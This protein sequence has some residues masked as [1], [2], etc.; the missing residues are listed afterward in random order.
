MRRKKAASVWWDVSLDQRTGDK[1]KT[2][3]SVY[4]HEPT[5]LDCQGQHTQTAFSSVVR[6]CQTW[7]QQLATC[8]TPNGCLSLSSLSSITSS[9]YCQFSYKK[10]NLRFRSGTKKCVLLKEIYN[11]YVSLI[12]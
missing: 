3:C 9:I 12:F 1:A 11:K 2:P 8:H 7:Q 10:N 4:K 5:V 6:K